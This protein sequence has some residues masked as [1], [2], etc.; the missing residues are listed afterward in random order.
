MEHDFSS[1]HASFTSEASATFLDKSKMLLPGIEIESD[2]HVTI[3]Y[4]LHD[5]HPPVCVIDIIETH[6]KFNITLGTIS[7]FRGED[8]NNDFDVVKVDINS[9]DVYALNAALA[10]SCDHTTEFSEYI[11]HATIAFVPKGSFDHLV[12]SKTLAGISFIVDRLVFSS[13]NG[14]QRLLFLGKK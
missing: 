14:S 13:K 1:I 2:P 9:S 7:L 11:P 8:S 5:D 10:N 12:G 4:G 6:P 3:L